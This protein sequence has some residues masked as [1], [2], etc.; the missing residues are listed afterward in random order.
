MQMSRTMCRKCKRRVTPQGKNFCKGCSG[1]QDA[2]YTQEYR[3]N[4]ER[5]YAEETHCWLCLEPVAKSERSV[6]HVVP[7]RHGGSNA[8]ANLRLAHQSCNSART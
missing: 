2:W 4:R 8:R 6:D 7:R 3:R 1:T 5:V